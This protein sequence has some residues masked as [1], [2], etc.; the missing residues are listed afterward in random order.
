M[1]IARKQLI[2]MARRNPRFVSYAA[3]VVLIAGAVTVIRA[4][5][6]DSQGVI[7]GCYNKSGGTLRVIDSTV[8]ACTPAY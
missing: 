1:N 4:S 3:A 5:I 2:D 6:P 7:H 8:T